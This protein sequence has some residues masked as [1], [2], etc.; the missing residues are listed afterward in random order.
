M[1]GVILC[2]GNSSRMRREKCF[3]PYHGMEQWR[4]IYNVMQQSCERIIISCNA[5][6][7][8]KFKDAEI[9]I[10]DLQYKNCGPAAGILSVFNNFQSS[11]YLVIGCDYPYFTKDDLELMLTYNFTTSAV[12]NIEAA[13]YE[14]LLAIYKKDAIIELKQQFTKGNYSLQYLLKQINACKIFLPIDAY[15]SIDTASDYENALLHFNT[16]Y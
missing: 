2:G 3:I 11:T 10:D 6:Q 16:E 7:A 5:S 8:D 13:L 12:Y 14:P 9:I 1:T 15:R 4:Y